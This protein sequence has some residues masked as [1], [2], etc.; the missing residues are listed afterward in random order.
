MRSAERGFTLLVMGFILGFLGLGVYAYEYRSAVLGFPLAV[1]LVTCLLCLGDLLK[2]RRRPAAARAGAATAPTPPTLA[3][4][5]RGTAWVVAV[6]PLVAV[7]G[8][9]IGLPLYVLIFLRAHGQGWRLSGLLSL[10]TLAVVY[11]GFAKLLGVPLPL[12]PMGLS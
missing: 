2:G 7:L 4:L 11:L 1:G 8:Y 12:P 6:L 5:G 9:A 10:A 3:E